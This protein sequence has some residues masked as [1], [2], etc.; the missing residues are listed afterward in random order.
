MAKVKPETRSAALPDEPEQM[1]LWRQILAHRD[2]LAAAITGWEDFRIRQRLGWQPLENIPEHSRAFSRETRDQSETMIRRQIEAFREQLDDL[3]M[4]IRAGSRSARGLRMNQL[5]ALAKR[6]PMKRRE[7]ATTWVKYYLDEKRKKSASAQMTKRTVQAVLE[8][9]T[10]RADI[11]ID[12][13]ERRAR[14]QRKENDSS[15][16]LI[17]KRIVD[18]VLSG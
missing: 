14:E 5:R 10:G 9:L 12:E 13:L 17:P 7:S 18:L 4:N 6:D 2:E 11:D 16:R 8:E 3:D 1:R 15:G